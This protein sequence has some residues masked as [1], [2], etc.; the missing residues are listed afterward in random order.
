MEGTPKYETPKHDL[1]KWESRSPS[2]PVS[3]DTSITSIMQVAIQKNYTPELIEKM[4]DLQERQ[5]ANQARKQYIVAI[6]NFKKKPLEI[7]KDKKVSFQTSKGKT[8]YDHASLANVVNTISTELGNHGL[9]ASWKTEQGDF[10]I[11]VTCVL[12][13]SEGHSEEVS[14]TAAP[15]TSGVKNQIQAVAS[16]VSYLERYTLLAITGLATKDMDNDGKGSDIIPEYIT[17]DMQTEIND[18]IKST[19]SDKAVFLKFVKVKSV[20]EIPLSEYGKVK[21]AFAAKLEAL[22]KDALEPGSAG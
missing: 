5:E 14:L 17:I 19:K 20:E 21:S 9:S 16:T 6:S 12:T 13:H 2:E 7:L 10:G 15:E 1:E 11:K 4:M 18:L 22:D 8:E 3:V